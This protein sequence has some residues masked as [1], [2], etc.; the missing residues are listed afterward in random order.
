MYIRGNIIISTT[1]YV[2]YSTSREGSID[3]DE[4]DQPT[5]DIQTKKSP[6]TAADGDPTY[7]MACVRRYITG[8]ESISQF[9]ENSRKMFLLQVRFNFFVWDFQ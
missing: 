7:E 3:R 1:F 4:E 6:G 2:V 5:G 9:I 8:S